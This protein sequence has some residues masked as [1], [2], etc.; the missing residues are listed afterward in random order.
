MD[1]LCTASEIFQTQINPE[2]SAQNTSQKTNQ[3][4]AFLNERDGM[5]KLIE[6]KSNPKLNYPKLPTLY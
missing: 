4:K 6:S 3:F 5:G 2:M 1:S